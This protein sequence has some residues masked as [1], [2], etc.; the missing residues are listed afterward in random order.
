ML[1]NEGRDN[2]ISNYLFDSTNYFDSE[3]DQPEYDFEKHTILVKLRGHKYGEDE[4]GHVFSLDIYVREEAKQVEAKTIE[5]IDEEFQKLFSEEDCI[6]QMPLLLAYLFDLINRTRSSP[7][8]YKKSLLS[9]LE[10]IFCHLRLTYRPSISF[11]YVK[12]ENP[13]LSNDDIEMEDSDSVRK[14]TFKLESLI[15]SDFAVELYHALIKKN[16]IDKESKETNFKNIFL[17]FFNEKIVWTSHLYLLRH[18]IRELIK[19]GFIVDKDRWEATVSSFRT[20][21]S[22]LTID[23]LQRAKDPEDENR[24]DRVNSIVTTLRGC[25]PKKL[26]DGNPTTPNKN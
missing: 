18:L 9:S 20:P 3:E 13:Q 12:N 4:L 14:I 24:L 16:L 19:V 17:G 15:R 2:Y 23:Q 25:M 22:D 6:I 11:L 1:T 26:G 8:S 5:R 21:K 10:R 7:F